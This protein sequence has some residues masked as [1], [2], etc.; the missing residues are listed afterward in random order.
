[1]INLKKDINKNSKNNCN[2][3]FFKDTEITKKNFTRNFSLNYF[4]NIN[5]YY[6]SLHDTNS[7]YPV[8]VHDCFALKLAVAITEKITTELIMTGKDNSFDK[9]FYSS[10]TLKVADPSSG[11]DDELIVIF[12]KQMVNIMRAGK[13]IAVR[14]GQAYITEVLQGKEVLY[15]KL[16]RSFWN[17]CDWR[18]IFPSS[19]EAAEKIYDNREAFLELIKAAVSETGIEDISNDFFNTTGICEANDYFMISFI[20]F[21]LLTWLKHFGLIE[22]NSK[23]DHE[24]VFI[25]VNDYG[26]EILNS[27]L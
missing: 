17:E 21:Y 4:N 1:M 27:F 26:R 12:L 20:D 23:S 9:K 16:L 24:L 11:F 7:V 5:R 2:S 14:D 8:A 6:L 25:S 13:L 19:P 15:P 18:D 22:Y 10:L 3:Y